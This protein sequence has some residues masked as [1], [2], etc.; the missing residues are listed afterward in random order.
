MK[1]DDATTILDEDEFLRIT[2]I[3]T[4]GNPE[5]VVTAAA[6]HLLEKYIKVKDQSK[7]TK[8]VC[9][10]KSE[11]QSSNSAASKLS[12]LKP[13]TQTEAQLQMKLL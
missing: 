10:E 2:L 8:A 9:N 11:K 13:T 6:I 3:R 4:K 12:S 7:I 1:L 5:S